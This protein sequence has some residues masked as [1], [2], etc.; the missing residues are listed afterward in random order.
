VADR[1]KGAEKMRRILSTMGCLL[2]SV[3]CRR[4]GGAL[5]LNG[6]LGE[7]MGM[8][9]AL[10]VFFCLFVSVSLSPAQDSGG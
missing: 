10:P 8:R 7:V 9:K 5:L 3:V 4:V 2:V 6:G 1:K